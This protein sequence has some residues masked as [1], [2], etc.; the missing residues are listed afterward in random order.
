MI[1]PSEWRG[2]AGAAAAAF[3]AIVAWLFKDVH[4]R[5]NSIEERKADDAE[6]L[7]QRADSAELWRA[8]NKAVDDVHAMHAQQMAAISS[9]AASV[10]RIEGKLSQ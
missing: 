9:V 10:A 1:E 5:L 2:I 7:R 8:H 6:L 3:T 4:A